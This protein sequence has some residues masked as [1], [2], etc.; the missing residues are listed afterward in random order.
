MPQYYQQNQQRAAPNQQRPMNGGSVRRA[1][2]RAEARAQEQMSERARPVDP[3][4]PP[5]VG[6]DGRHYVPG[7]ATR[8]MYNNTPLSRQAEHM[9]PPPAVWRTTPYSSNDGS[10]I[11]S[12]ENLSLSSKKQRDR[13]ELA[14]DFRFPQVP[15]STTASPQRPRGNQRQHVWQQAP[16]QTPESPAWPLPKPNRAQAAQ[17]PPDAPQMNVGRMDQPRAANPYERESVYSR[18][19][20]PGT[21]P[22]PSGVVRQASQGKRAKPTLTTIR[23]PDRASYASPKSPRANTINALSTAIAAGMAPSSRPETPQA[24]A[25]PSPV[26]MPFADDSPPRSPFNEKAPLEP[27][28]T[29]ER[30]PVTT[31][32]SGASTRSH[33]PLLSVDHR[34]GMSDRIPSSR[35]PPRLNMEAVREAE[36]RGSTTSLAELIRRATKLAS[37]LDRGKTASR[38]GM[39]DMFNAGEKDKRASGSLSDMLSA[40]P[41]PGMTPTSANVHESKFPPGSSHLRNGEFAPHDSRNF[42]PGQ[43]KGRRCCGMSLTAFF[44]VMFVLIILIAAAVLVPLFLIV[45]PRMHNSSTSLSHCSTSHPCQN[46]GISV[47][48]DN[49]CNCICTDGYTGDHC[50][51]PIAADC[52]TTDVTI[53][54]QTYN[55]ATAGSSIPALLSGSSKTFNIPLNSTALLSL[56]A[57]NNLTCITENSLVN[58]NVQKQ[59]RFFPIHLQEDEVTSAM[60]LPTTLACIDARAPQPQMSA[61]AST[62]GIV[63]QASTTGSPASPASTSRAGS[64]TS[65]APSA[66]TTMPV[67]A[68][69]LSF[70]QVVVLYVF[71]QSNTLSIAVNAQQTLQ[72]YLAGVGGSANGTISVGYKELEI[73]ADFGRFE[74]VWGNG[75]SVGG[76]G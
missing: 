31:T 18:P 19:S 27:P 53:G 2:E 37:N 9:H 25:K 56:F 43:P 48:S 5:S 62:D 65:S 46:L 30:S 57:A 69:T 26:R 14:Q 45:I 55:S 51:Q 63:Y 50:Q 29:L 60:P 12:A 34:P 21:P 8:P 52:A 68:Q 72:S 44:V 20:E 10:P 38:L 75:S 39:L 67:S 54:T 7:E 74:V 35:R 42:Q 28:R 64:S 58:F 70:A 22:T 73:S 71:E 1:R 76:K 32:D 6:D 16:Q 13:G 59:K 66:H 41:E 61:I 24:Q 40:F 11:S 49:R 17:T 4:W 3:R 23:S 15:K 36:S 33:N 47:V